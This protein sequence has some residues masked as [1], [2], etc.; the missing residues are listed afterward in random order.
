MPNQ[1]P[2][3][4]GRGEVEDK[5]S[6]RP[7]HEIATCPDNVVTRPLAIVRCLKTHPT[8]PEGITMAYEESVAQRIRPLLNDEEEVAERKMF[9]GLAFMV[10]G[11]MCC[12][13]IGEE[14]MLRVGP[15]AYEEVLAL[16]H[17]RLMDFTGRPMK[18]FVYVA[19][20]GFTTDEQL[21]GWLEPALRFV[22]SM[23][24]K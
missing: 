12:G 23:P 10:N 4:S 13:V 19:K 9:G 18:G 8:A 11:H 17:A 16:E 2:G 3:F 20:E 5:S 14:L 15:E 7:G 21:A 22:N 6:F 24:P 1:L